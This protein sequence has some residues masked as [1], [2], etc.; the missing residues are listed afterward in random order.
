MFCSFIKGI[1]PKF[2]MLCFVLIN[3]VCVWTSS[4]PEKLLFSKTPLRMSKRPAE[5]STEVVVVRMSGEYWGTGCENEWG[6][7][8]YW[9]WEWGGEHRGTGCENE[10]GSTEVLDVRMRWEALRYWMWEWGGEY[11]GTGCEN[12]WGV[13][14]YWMWEW[15]GSTEVLDVRMSKSW[16][17]E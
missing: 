14:R 1:T 13:L 9:M 4:L 3:S 6:V 8:R 10:V 2:C 16:E 11:W 12:E 5:G 15:V 7:L 17:A